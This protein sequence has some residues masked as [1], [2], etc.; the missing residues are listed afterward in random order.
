[1]LKPQ[2]YSG[3]T[4]DFNYEV[5]L[6]SKLLGLFGKRVRLAVEEESSEVELAEEIY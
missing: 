2:D 1:M 5:E 6:R 4:V 3:K